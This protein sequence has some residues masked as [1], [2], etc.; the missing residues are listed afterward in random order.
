MKCYNSGC[1]FTTPNSVIADEQMYWYMLAK[2][3]G[4]T[5]FFNDSR[6][7]SSNDLIF[8]RVYKHVLSNLTA[9]TFYIINLT[10][11]NR[12]ELEQSQSEKL[13]EILKPEALVRY[14]FETLE[15]TL[16]AQLIGIVSFLNLHMKDFY[17]VNNSKALSDTQWAPRDAFI[18]FLKKE[19]RA[20]N[21]F[22]FSK[23]EFHQEVSRVKPY[24]YS[25]YG[26]SGHDG[27]DGHYA[28]YSKLKTI[29]Q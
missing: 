13:Q 26:W 4:C 8:Q 10:S 21:L 9:E 20:L 22:N 12:M 29:A 24:D 6:P 17:I 15:L 18:D 25:L 3:K 16:F 7:G 2:D 28:Y 23:Y 19:K 14:D 1:S 11:L 5:E 27:P